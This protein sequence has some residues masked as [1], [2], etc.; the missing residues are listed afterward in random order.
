[1]ALTLRLESSPEEE[2]RQAL[3]EVG[4]IAWFRLNDIFPE[5]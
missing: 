4:R 3:W 1:V 5:S 2:F